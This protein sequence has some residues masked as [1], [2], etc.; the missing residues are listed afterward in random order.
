MGVGV[1]DWETATKLIL[2]VAHGSS[3]KPD[4]YVR[5]GHACNNR[6]VFCTPAT[7][8]LYGNR[9]TQAVIDAVDQ[10]ISEGQVGR[11]VYSGGEPTVRPD[12][13]E[14]LRY[15]EGLGI[16]EQNIQTNARKLSDASYLASLRDSGLTSCFVSIHGP[17][18][19]VHDWLTGSPGAFDQTCAGL[20]NL[21]RLGISLVTNT[22][23]C[24]QNYRLLSELVVFLGRTFQS[25]N[26]IKLSYPRLQDGAAENLTEIIAPL[27]EVAQSVRDA[28]NR[29]KEVGV[30]VE[31]E[32]MP[33]CLLGTNYDR[34]D[35]FYTTRYSLSDLTH[36]DSN[37]CRQPSDVFY[38]VCGDCDVRNRCLGIDTL[39]HEAFGENPCF[40]PVSFADLVH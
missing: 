28:I 7:T 36:F 20:T 37:Y 22:V 8:K 15:A 30:Y 11:M 12:L 33:I 18:A 26:T 2:M 38:K 32:S 19:G 24:R 10:I 27:W 13:P 14:I 39:H 31:T 4:G 23:I 5:L 17:Q 1:V 40:S 34:A 35:N 16:A 21:E 25:I 6:C 29:G 9:D 3:R